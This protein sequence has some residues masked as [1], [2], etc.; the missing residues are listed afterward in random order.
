[1]VENRHANSEVSW[2]KHQSI[3]SIFRCV[4]ALSVPIDFPLV[5]LCLVFFFLAIIPLQYS[6]AA[7]AVQW[8]GWRGSE[9]G[10]TGSIS[11]QSVQITTFVDTFIFFG[12]GNLNYIANSLAITM[13]L[14]YMSQLRSNT[15]LPIRDTASLIFGAICAIVF[16]FPTFSIANAW[17]QPFGTFSAWVAEW[18]LAGLGEWAQETGNYIEGLERTQFTRTAA[19]LIGF[20]VLASFPYQSWGPSFSSHLSRTDGNW[21]DFVHEI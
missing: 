5:I 14:V 2:L 21:V 8:I 7:Y 19:L 6:V 16:L 12:D 13:L 18:Q 9:S 1:M 11:D 17:L 10:M 15:L 3:G 20:A 4:Q